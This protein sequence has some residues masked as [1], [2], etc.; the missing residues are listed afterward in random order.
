MA[1]L[2]SY[3]GQII[4]VLFL[5]VIIIILFSLIIILIA[6]LLGKPLYI[7]KK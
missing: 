7:N 2:I 6:A 1:S 4:F 5:I 3:L